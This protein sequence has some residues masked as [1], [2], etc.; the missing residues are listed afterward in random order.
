[1]NLEHEYV[2]FLGPSGGAGGASAMVVRVGGASA[3]VVWV[4]ERQRWW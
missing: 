4:R 3:M 2:P 1:M